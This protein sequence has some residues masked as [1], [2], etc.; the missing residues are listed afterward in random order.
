MIV[1]SLT[2]LLA[3]SL[4]SQVAFADDVDRARAQFKNG[5]KLYDLGRYKEAAQAYEEAYQAKDEPAL[6]Y[7]IAQAYRLGADF[8]SAVRFY[9]SFLRRVP[10]TPNRQEVEGRIDELQKTIAQQSTAKE[11]PPTAVMTMP[12]AVA[13]VTS[14]ATTPAIAATM[15]PPRK[16]SRAWI[17]ALAAGGAVA[18]GLG[19]GLGVGLN[20][21]TDPKPSLGGVTVR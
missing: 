9:K 1:R 7:N 8:P 6:L 10:N 2:A 16:R 21:D 17:W 13:P 20:H 19:V 4:I 5:T 11:G 3:M 15:P 12:Q 18:I 14:P